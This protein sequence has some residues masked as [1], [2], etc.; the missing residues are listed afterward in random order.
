MEETNMEE[1]T[2]ALQV[3]EGTHNQMA[4]LSPTDVMQQVETIQ[5]LM[6][7][8]MRKDEHFGIVPGC[9][10]PSL[11][12]PGAEKLGLMFRL[13]AR[14]KIEKQ[15]LGNGHREITVT[16]GLHHINTGA[17]WGEGVGSCST[18]ETK[19]RYR[20]N[21]AISTGRPVPKE[22]WD[23]KRTDPKKAQEMLGGPKFMPKKLDDGW[24]ICEKGEKQENPEIADTY[25]TVLK[26]AKKRA[27]VDAMLNATAASDIFTQDIE[28]AA[29][30]ARSSPT[31]TTPPQSS[32][33]KPQG[34]AAESAQL[35]TSRFSAP[36]MFT[37]KKNGK[38][39]WATMDTE[40]S[41]FFIFSDT[42]AAEISQLADRQLTVEIE[43]TE[44][45]TRIVG[46]IPPQAA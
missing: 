31:P 26:M 5:E 10:K 9:I 27:L 18:M 46:V 32:A 30:A 34:Q 38:G 3:V 29:P 25:N 43:R 13:A 19:Y 16:C 17:F 12:K 41:K 37:S 39:Y 42:I 35:Y 4:S 44:K 6:R 2:G 24:M 14:Y 28:E 33:A 8:A 1:G 7:K 23:L 20:G 21:E 22:Y 36:E 45:G 11:L 15:D 40:G